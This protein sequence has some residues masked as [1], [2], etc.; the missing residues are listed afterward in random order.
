M[1]IS[2]YTLIKKEISRFLKL[3]IQTVAPSFF[4]IMIYFLLFKEIMSG[5]IYLSETSIKYKCYI[6]YSLILMQIMQISFSAVS[7][8]FFNMKYQRSI[9][10]L[11][12][13]PMNG[14]S[15]IMSFLFI[16]LIR[17]FLVCG[18]AYFAFVS[19]GVISLSFNINIILFLLIVS[20]IFALVG[21]LN[22][23]FSKNFDNL[24]IFQ[25]FIL[26]PLI[27]LSG[28]FYPVEA[29]SS[30]F[31]NFSIFNPCYYIVRIYFDLISFSESRIN[32]LNFL[33]LIFIFILFYFISL[34]II[35][36]RREKASEVNI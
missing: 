26:T 14:F 28:I 34:H 2:I 3:W 17:S 19:F 21:L 30:F 16:G 18:L 27:Y 10:Y 4:S 7:A 33:F 6:V 5:N 23:I 32:F 8:S 15:I 22:A 24:S 29:M 20:S 11:F 9:L 13:T 1:F 12:T 36:N 31:Q 25:S 35:N